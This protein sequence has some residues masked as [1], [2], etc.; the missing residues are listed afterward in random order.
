VRKT[1][2]LALALLAIGIMA[3][4]AAFV[5]LPYERGDLIFE[6]L[7]Y[8]G[9]VF[10]PAGVAL[11]FA[12]L[13]SKANR[14]IRILIFSAA[15]FFA[16]TFA[17]VPALNY[18]AAIGGAV[19]LAVSLVFRSK[20][21]EKTAEEGGLSIESEKPRV[22]SSSFAR[23]FAFFWIGTVLIFFLL[24]AYNAGSQ[25]DS[26]ELRAEPSRHFR[27]VVYLSQDGKILRISPLDEAGFQGL[28][29]QERDLT[30]I[31]DVYNRRGGRR[32]NGTG[33]FSWN[34]E[35]LTSEDR[36]EEV[37][38]WGDWHSSPG[39]ALSLH[40]TDEYRT[41]NFTVSRVGNPVGS[42]IAGS[43][44]Y[45]TITVIVDPATLS[46]TLPPAMPVQEASL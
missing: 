3:N 31:A 5:L 23:M 21:A 44:I 4:L 20:P 8:I 2:T 22:E 36:Y 30:L 18:F 28:Y 45:D 9:S 29:M 19:L 10:A 38:G 35:G 34:I 13:F 12:L 14:H 11:L 41:L 26:V 32:V 15:A 43:R 25:A 42:R 17:G 27:T 39:I 7:F 37:L 24:S 1:V 16:G 6:A 33:I 46:A 40:L